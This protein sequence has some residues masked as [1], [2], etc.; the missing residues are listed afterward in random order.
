MAHKGESNYFGPVDLEQLAKLSERF[1]EV[2]IHKLTICLLNYPGLVPEWMPYLKA[3]FP[4]KD[5]EDLSGA[6]LEG[7][8]FTAEILKEGVEQGARFEDWDLRLADVAS[9]LLDPIEG[10]SLKRLSDLFAKHPGTRQD[11]FD[12]VNVLRQ[13]G[14]ALRETVN[15]LALLGQHAVDGQ[16]TVDGEKYRHIVTNVAEWYV[17]VGLDPIKELLESPQ[18]PVFL[19]LLSM[20]NEIGTFN[21]GQYCF[22]NGM[23]LSE[24]VDLLED[25]GTPEAF[26]QTCTA[27]LDANPGRIWKRERGYWDELYDYTR[28]IATLKNRVL[29]ETSLQ[30]IVRFWRDVET[31]L[32]DATGRL[33]LVRSDLEFLRD[34]FPNES[35]G[36]IMFSVDYDMRVL[37][38]YKMQ[39]PEMDLPTAR[40]RFTELVNQIMGDYE[41]KSNERQNI[42]SKYDSWL[43]SQEVRKVMQQHDLDSS[44]EIREFGTLM[45]I[46][47]KA[48]SNPEASLD[49]VARIVRAKRERRQERREG[50]A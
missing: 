48:N 6:A 18:K 31:K 38:R 15:L 3:I 39:D 19:Q 50:R 14:L 37:R 28:D 10:V 9:V 7:L 21:A 12:A 8:G 20:P 30:D 43:K 32:G 5:L 29:P 46:I 26:Q 22:Q 40:N 17:R 13:K 25:L 16:T 1:P 11:G 2:E 45:A 24:I 36:E 27:V 34:Y 23:R 47:I 33:W 44:H 41:V 35:D 42:L 49:D 4:K